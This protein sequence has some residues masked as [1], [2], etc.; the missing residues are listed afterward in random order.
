MRLDLRRS[1]GDSRATLTIAAILAAAFVWLGGRSTQASDAVESTAVQ[2]TASATTRC[3]TLRE[4]DQIWLI[5]TRDLGCPN[6]AWPPALHVWLY[7]GAGGWNESSV[8]AFLAADNPQMPTVFYAHGNFDSADDAVDR[9]LQVYSRLA[10]QTPSDRP[11]R[12]VIWSWPTDRDKHPL[13]VTRMHAHRADADAYYLGWLVNR[14]DHRVEVGLVGYSLGARVVTGAL[15][16]LGGGELIGLALE[17]DPKAPHQMVR[18][19]LL[20][21]AE[22]CDWIVAG[23]PNGQTIPFV[24]RM[25]LLNNGC[26]SVL[27]RYPHL[28]RCDHSEALGYVGICGPFDSRKVEQLDVC[29]AIGP[30]HDWARYF[31]NDSLVADMLPYL[32]LGATK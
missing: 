5:S 12:F 7:N 32:F 13:R 22:D 26:D 14:I 15:H 6:G 30:E 24:D 31:Y 20:A 9:G 4:H 29:C 16:L 8:D 28:E 11:M 18:A 2:P 25:L 19:A 17:I 21:A 1:R 3:G 10:A 27:K 23:H